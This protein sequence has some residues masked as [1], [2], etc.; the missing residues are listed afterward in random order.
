[1]IFREE[2]VEAVMLKDFGADCANEG[3]TG[4]DVGPAGAFTLGTARLSTFG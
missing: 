4:S 1:M 3:P 2:A